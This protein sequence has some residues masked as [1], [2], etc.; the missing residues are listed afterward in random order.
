LRYKY[1]GRDNYLSQL[2]W[3]L[4]P[5]TYIGAAFE[6]SPTDPF[7]ERGGVARLSLKFGVPVGGGSMEDRDWLADLDKPWSPENREYMTHFSRH[8]VGAESAFLSDIFLGMNYPISKSFSIKPYAKIS[9]MRF[10]WIAQNGFFQYPDTPPENQ[11]PQEN[12]YDKPWTDALPRQVISGPVVHYEQLWIYLAPGIFVGARVNRIF[13][14]GLSF[15]ISPLVFC[16]AADDHLQLG[17]QYSKAK[18]TQDYMVLG[19]MIEEEVEFSFTLGERIEFKAGASFRSVTGSRGLTYVR[20]TGIRK[21]EPR[22]RAPNDAGAEISYF[23]AG[24]GLKFQ[25]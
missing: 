24:L 17:S 18:E 21:D 7:R 4:K 5:M 23:E 10:S 2:I 1:P 15:N 16:Y 12:I 3:D 6:L 9:L 13:S 25:F 8:D 14:L 19:L 20:D 22:I 11:K